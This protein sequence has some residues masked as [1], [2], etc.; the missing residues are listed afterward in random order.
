MHRHNDSTCARHGIRTSLFA[1]LAACSMLIFLLFASNLLAQAPPMAPSNLSATAVSSSQI[2]LTWTDN[3]NSPNED[4]FA[5]Q[6]S[7]TSGSGFVNIGTTVN[8][9]NYSDNSGLAEGTTYYYRVGAFIGTDTSFSNQASITTHPG[10]PSTL[11]ATAVSNDQIN[12]TWV[13]N[14][15]AESGFKIE[16]ATVSGGPFT[17]IATVGANVVFYV[18]SGLDPSTTYYYQVR[19]Y[20]GATNSAYSNEASAT[21]L[22]DPPAAASSLT[23]TAVSNNQIDLAWLDNSSNEDGFKIERKLTSGVTYIQIDVVGAG[24]TSY[25]NNGLFS[26]TAYTYRVRAFNTGGNSAYS[27]TA[28]ATTLVD[29]PTAPD[30]LAAVAAGIGGVN[31]TWGDDSNNED[32]FKIERKLTAATLSAF[33]QIAQVGSNSENY[34]DSGL[35][36]VTAYTYRVR[37]FR[38]TPNSHSAYTDTV[39]VTTNAGPPSPP[40]AP[41]SLVATAVSNEEINLEWDDNSHIPNNET[42]FN[43]EISLNAGGPFDPIGS[44]SADDTTFSITGLDPDTQYFFRVNGFNAGGNSTYSN[45]AN[46]TTLPNPPAAPSSLSATAV[47]FTQ[48]N[49]AWTDNANNELGFK[50]E[51]KLNTTGASYSQIDMV[52]PNVTSYSN[53]GLTVNTNYVYRVRSYNSIGNSAYSNEDNAT[54]NVPAAPSAMS[55]TAISNIQIDLTW[56]DN[57]GDEAGFIIEVKI[58]AG[59]TYST[60]DSVGVNDTDYSTTALNPSTNYFFRVFAYN[61]VGNSTPSNEDDATTLP[62]PAVAPSNLTATAVSNNQINLSWSDNSN[63]EEGFKIERKLTSSVT[64]TEIDIVGPNVTSYASS[65]LATNTSYTYRVR[66]YSVAGNSPY[67]NT[68]SA[69]T[70]VNSPTAPDSLTAN[71]VNFSQINLVWGDDSN[72]EE[73]FK[74]ERKLTA[75]PV[76]A[77]TQIGTVGSNVES[78]ADMGP[79]TAS[80]AYTYRVRAFNTGGLNNS[81][82]SDTASATTT[83]GPPNAP[84]NLRAAAFNNI[85]INLE[86]HDN[87]SDETN[88]TIE[89]ATS[90]GGTY[91][92]IGTNAADDTT[93]SVNGLV[94]NTIYYF[95]VYAANANGN[96]GYSNVASDTTL[97]DL[98]NAPSSLA[99][100][101]I[102]ANRIDITWQDN[103]NDEQGFKIERK[104]TSSSTFNQIAVL[105]PGVTSYS[106]TGLTANTSYSFRVRAYNVTGNSA[107]SNTASATSLVSAPSAP[108]A[109]IATAVSTSQIDLAWTDNASNEDGFKVERLAPGDADYAEIASLAAG[110]VSYSSTGL[111]ANTIYSYRVRAFR[112]TPNSFSAYSNVDDD[113][114]FMAT[115]NAPSNLVATTISNVQI[116][117]SWNDQSSNELGFIIERKVGAGGTYATVDSVDAGT[118]SYSNTGLFGNTTYFYR[119]KAYNANGNSPDSNE[120]DALTLLYGPTN[121]A[122]TAFSSSQINLSWTDNSGSEIGFKIERKTGPGGTYAQI[123]TAAANVTAYSNTGLAASTQYFY[124]VRSYNATNV[125][126]YSNEDDATTFSPVP[127]PATPSALAAT[128]VSKNQIDLAWTDNSTNED[129]F[130]IERKTGAAGTF[131]EVGSVAAG[132]TAFNNTGLSVNTKYFYRV[133]AFNTGGNSAYSN[134]ASATTFLNGPSNLAAI[135]VSTAQIN[136]SWTDNTS[137]ETSFQIERGAAAGGPFT[138]VGT[139]TQNAVSFQNTGLT[140]NTLYFYRVRAINASNVSG[141]S[142]VASDTTFMASGPPPNAPSN[143]TATAATTSQINLAWTD[144]SSD[145]TGFLVE[146]SLASGGPFTQI[147]ATAANATSFSNGGLAAS[148]QYFYRVRATNAGNN[149]AYSSEANATTLT[150]NSSNLALNKAA[151]ASSTD[152]TSTTA[153]AVDGNVVSFWRSGPTSGNPIAWIYVDLG[154]AMTVGRA[155]VRWSQNYFANQYEIQVSNDAASW[156][157]VHTNNSGA[158]GMQDISFTQTS[159]RYVRLYLKLNEKGNYRVVEF[160]VYANGVPKAADNEVADNQAVIPEDMTLEQN[161]PNPFNPSTTISFSLAESKQVTLKVVNVTG[162]EV[163]TL[164][165]GYRN[166]GTHRVTFKATKLPSGT[167]YAV[168]KSGEVTQIRRMTLAK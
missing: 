29:P 86:W 87:S 97:P 62:D 51:R 85:Q 96:S 105:G 67:S 167:Y 128:P 10:A 88:F 61:L 7:T 111:T 142:N 113:T 40:T 26:S 102:T 76:S 124:R 56:T 154:S 126:G 165:D 140:A 148:T 77:F 84:G 132:V 9:T 146:R 23:A 50:I 101:A 21:T 13:D 117:L 145:E 168:L 89:L 75:A 109:L 66:A 163:A 160:E 103:S 15:S 45:V 119:V 41:D 65:G 78:Y 5:I 141:Y 147:T 151:T 83:S 135:A 82:Y 108:S 121:L 79:L 19:A 155:V 11:A 28:S 27:N 127:P 70:F 38:G 44:N 17:Q 158:A 150:P 49:L 14:A 4:G 30:S 60:L 120:D 138:Q 8:I 69:A 125:S 57:S 36:P 152:P 3:S 64:F 72:D 53:T 33:T 110:A 32:G 153:R 74:I 94:P 136:L 42:G 25:S 22:P 144:N 54:T 95:R 107:Y 63:N 98:P 31:L 47:S 104:L 157:I 118:T 46:A 115:P 149:S 34:S 81:A 92:E 43:I 93:I 16:I 20:T 1:G 12:L 112:G 52:G 162:Q 48:I 71:G 58:N 80:T 99:A 59:G 100:T 166:S 6:R 114:T 55:A 137:N 130:K 164:V 156:T 68:A 39:S 159:A 134:D 35:A 90:S 24:V 123:D 91:T 139:A 129:G 106:S 143:L 2:D 133:R 18:S 161:Y 73:G 131:A 116:D 37:A 122:A